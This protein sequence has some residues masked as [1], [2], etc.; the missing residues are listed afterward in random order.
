[1]HVAADVF[2]IRFVCAFGPQPPDGVAGL[3]DVFAEPDRTLPFLPS[4]NGDAAG[5]I[6]VV[7]FDVGPDGLIPVPRSHSELIAG[8]LAVALESRI[9]PNSTLL[10][11]LAT[12]S[13]AG[14]ATTVLPWLFSAGTLSLHQPFDPAVFTQQWDATRF[15]ILP[16]PFVRQMSDT[17]AWSMSDKTIIALWRSPERY[18]E[19]ASWNASANLIDVLAFG[20]VGIVAAAR[21]SHG[22]AAPLRLGPI[23]APRGVAGANVLIDIGATEHGTLALGG[24]MVPSHA[25]LPGMPI[26]SAL[27]F[28]AENG[29]ADTFQPCRVAGNGTVALDGAPAGIVSVGGYRFVLRELQDLITDVSDDSTVAAVPDPVAGHRLAGIGSNPAA[30]REALAQ[31]GANALIVEAFEVGRPDSDRAPPLDPGIVDDEENA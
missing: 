17:D 23:T 21:A 20:E 30:V 31:K 8:G 12:S 7:T 1:M 29:F 6:A 26:N 11:A 15:A 24:A 2:T 9:G 4:G 28:K 13:F 3:D 27:R 16:A 22:I 10:G 5:Q 25:F 19:D 18:A 14:L